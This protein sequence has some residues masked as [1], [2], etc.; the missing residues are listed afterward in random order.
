MARVKKGMNAHKRHKKILRQAKGFYGQKHKKEIEAAQN[1]AK[2]YG[3][4]LITLDLGKIFSYS[5]CS[6]LEGS[7][8]EIPEGSYEEQLK[9][10]NG[11]PV[12][13]YVPASPTLSARVAKT[14]STEV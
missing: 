4:E 8:N 5:D 7:S 10:T 3:V 1:I 9:E 12:S 6:L 2:F 13:T 11:S 14:C